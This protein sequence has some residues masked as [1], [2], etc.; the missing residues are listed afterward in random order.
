MSKASSGS[1]MVRFEPRNAG[2]REAEKLYWQSDIL[3]L[4][5]PAGTGKSFAGVAFALREIHDAKKKSLYIIRPPVEATSRSLGFLPGDLDEKLAPYSA[6]IDKLVAKVGLRVPRDVVSTE[7]LAH[8]RGETYDDCVVLVDEC[9]NLTTKEFTL[10]VS[11][12]GHNARMVFCGDP[13]QSD[14]KPT[15]KTHVTDLDFAVDR[16]IDEPGVSVVEFDP[17]EIVRNPRIARWL[18][19]LRN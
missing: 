5:G 14:I 16:L 4:I 2:Q 3:F 11:R 9:Q 12:L 18:T 6:P 1:W 7:S 10:L 17:S 19:A 13:D 8:A 15:Q